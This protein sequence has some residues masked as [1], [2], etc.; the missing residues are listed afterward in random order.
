[1]G[2]KKTE[3]GYWMGDVSPSIKITSIELKM[4][5]NIVREETTNSSED[6]RF[7]RFPVCLTF[8]ESHKFCLSFF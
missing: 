8:P 4:A 2:K 5:N 1:M 6:S 3:L 7:I